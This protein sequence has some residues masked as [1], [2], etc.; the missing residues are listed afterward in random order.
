MLAQDYLKDGNLAETLSAV[1]TAVME[2][3]SKVENRTFLFQLLAVTGE[4][5]RALNQLN[6]AGE[7]DPAAIPMVQT[8]REA[9]GCEALRE[10]VFEGQRSPL[11][12]GDPEQWIALVL[13]SVKLGGQ[14]RHAEAAKMRDEAYESAPTVS[15]SINGD[16]FEWI[17][18]ADSRIGPFMEAIVNGK[19]YWIPFHRIASVEIEPPADLRDLVWTPAQFSWANG[20]QAIGL[21]PARYPGTQDSGNDALILGRLTDWDEQS[22]GTYCGLGQKMYA[23]DQND[24]PLLEIR[25]IK[26][27]VEATPEA[28]E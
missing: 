27:D 2:D 26:L 9:L 11:V 12:F 13:E 23:T 16:A 3:P 5:E 25:E 10:K 28:A 19:Y 21:L 1:K 15:G 14:G 22:E 8:Y 6:L 17:A 24:Y 4:W 20:G 7:L 18:D